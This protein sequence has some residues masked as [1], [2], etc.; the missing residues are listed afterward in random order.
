MKK[1]T[2]WINIS[3]IALIVLGIIHLIA[4]IMVLPMFQNLGKEQFHVFLFMY[5]AAGF[6]TVLPGL[7]S[8]LL[9]NKVRNKDKG[10]WGIIIIC[11]IYSLILGLGA[12]VFMNTNPFAYLMLLIGF[13]LFIPSILIK[14]EL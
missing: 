6:G 7:I 8:K 5:L 11:S 3:C 14:K 2:N 1:L 13:S 10:A 4:T 12:I 9:I